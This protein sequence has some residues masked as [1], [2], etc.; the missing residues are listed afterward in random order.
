[1]VSMDLIPTDPR[2]TKSVS[3]PVSVRVRIHTDT[4]LPVPLHFPTYHNLFACIWRLWSVLGMTIDVHLDLIPES[5]EGRNVDLV[6][7]GDNIFM[8]VSVTVLTLFCL[9]EAI[10]ECMEITL[11]CAF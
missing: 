11:C 9:V 6:P 10:A 5:A 2:I 4:D 8:L 3:V 1:M 7:V